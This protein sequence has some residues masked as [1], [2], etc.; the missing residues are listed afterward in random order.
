MDQSLTRALDRAYA[1]MTVAHE[2]LALARRRNEDAL[3]IITE[4]INAPVNASLTGSGPDT[5]SAFSRRRP[6]RAARISKLDTDAELRVFVLSRVDHL[7]FEQIADAVA[8]A[9]PAERCLG[10]SA[11]HAWWRQQSRPAHS[12]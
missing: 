3:S 10:K 7:S 8:N 1:A 9:F 6:G 5:Y 12:E 11:I 4:I 2:A